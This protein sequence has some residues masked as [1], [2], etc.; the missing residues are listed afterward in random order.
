MEELWFFHWGKIGVGHWKILNIYIYIHT[1][2]TRW[3]WGICWCCPRAV[4]FWAQWTQS[5]KASVKAQPACEFPQPDKIYNYHFFTFLHISSHFFTTKFLSRTVRSDSKQS[6]RWEGNPSSFLR[7]VWLK[8][9]ESRKNVG[10]FS[11]KNRWHYSNF[12]WLNIN[13]FPSRNL[14]KKTGVNR[15]PASPPVLILCAADP[16]LRILRLG[17]PHFRNPPSLSLYIYDIYT[18]TS[19]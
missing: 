19:Y 8:S 4:D 6:K 10:I 17:Y 9:R 13:K 16:A 1:V 14:S 2:M 11:L 5:V 18:H 15:V 7:L 12:W 3:P